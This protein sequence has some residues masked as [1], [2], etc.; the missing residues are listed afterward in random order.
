[1][2]NDQDKRRKDDF[3]FMV[4]C[5]AKGN[6]AMYELLRD[7]SLDDEIREVRKREYMPARG[8]APPE[9]LKGEAP[10]PDPC[11]DLDTTG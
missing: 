7:R 5:A 11:D 3:E 9:W 4:L 2:S 8:D 10:K 1:M 6:M